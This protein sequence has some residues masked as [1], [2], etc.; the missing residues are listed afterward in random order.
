MGRSEIKKPKGKTTSSLNGLRPKSDHC[1]LGSL[2]KK[3]K[4]KTHQHFPL[5][6]PDQVWCWRI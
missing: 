3:K 1:N 6:L 5:K 4:Y 2:M